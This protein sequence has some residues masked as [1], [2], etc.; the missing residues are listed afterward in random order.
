MLNFIKSDKNNKYDSEDINFSNIPKHI[1]IIMDGN[2]RWAKKKNL[3]RTMGHKAGG[4]AL[5]RIVRECSDLGVKYLTVYAFST[6]NWIRPKEEVSAIMRLIV[7]F[8]KREFN[9]LHK[10]N[11]ILNTVGDISKLPES[12][13]TALNDA[14]EKTKNNT[15]IMLNLALNYGGRNEILNAI[16][17]IFKDYEN[18]KLSK[19]DILNLN[20]DVFSSYLYTGD[21]PDPDIIIRPSGEKRL[22]NFLLWQCAYSEFWYSNINWPDFSKEDLHNAIRDYQNRNRRFGGVK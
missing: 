17:N 13:I 19:D 4:E 8:L 16:K 10:N 5:K 2:G 20:E 11:V 7:E 1:A 18:N 6:E 14:K 15:G 9:E 21:M 12:C 3:P 22:S